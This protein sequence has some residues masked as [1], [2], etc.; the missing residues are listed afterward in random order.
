MKLNPWN[1][2][3]P[4]EAVAGLVAAGLIAIVAT[5]DSGSEA[6]SIPAQVA[7]DVDAAIR[8]NAEATDFGEWRSSGFTPED[9]F[10]YLRDLDGPARKQAAEGLC[11]KLLAVRLEDLALFEDALSVPGNAARLTCTPALRHRLENY[12]L[13]AQAA[14]HAHHM[15]LRMDTCSKATVSLPSREERI[16]ALTGPVL[17]SGDLKDKEIA[18]TFDDGPHPTRSHRLLEILKAAGVRATYFQVGEMAQESPEVS[19]DVALAGHSVGSHSWSHPQLNR[20]SLAAAEREI[21]NGH[22]VVNLHS[23]TEIP[24]FRFPYGARSPALQELVKSKGLATFFWNMDSLDWK[25]H[26]PTVLFDRVVGE[27]EREGRGILLFHDIHEQTVLVMPHVLEELARRG[28]TTV[29]YVPH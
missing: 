27:I 15:H 29:V 3:K 11:D 18:L 24:F 10:Q 13:R 6:V 19:R 28:F 22:G 25:I 12:W 2:V 16:D 1:R 20:L 7:E 26:S 17:T 5:A 9:I 8:K 14:L 23:G 21:V 4:G